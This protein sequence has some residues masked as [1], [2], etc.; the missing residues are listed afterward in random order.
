MTGRG[1]AERAW[2]WAALLSLSACEARH[3]PSGGAPVETAAAPSDPATEAA[4]AALFAAADDLD[5]V[6]F[7]T[8]LTP[9]SV[10]LLDAAISAGST[11]GRAPKALPLSW[12]DVMEAHRAVTATGRTR[13]PYRLVRGTDA[14][15]NRLDLTASPLGDLARSLLESTGG[16]P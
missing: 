9:E 8:R 7:K 2:V 13:T 11:L 10:A 1:R 16:T 14:T 3:D 15:S 5:L 4:H 6:A 12:E